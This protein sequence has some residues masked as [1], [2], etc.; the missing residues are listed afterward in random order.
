MAR[1]AAI[2]ITWG[3]SVRGREGK[4][5]EVFMES[6]QFWGKQ[7]ADG[8]IEPPETFIAEDGSGGM[9]ILR[10]KSD[11]LQQLNETDDARKLLSK[12]QLIVEDLRSHWYYTGDEEITRETSLFAQVANELGYM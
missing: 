9:V 1:N 4:S 10:G 2:V 12:A 6:L 11:V 5:L 7:A 8:K 3:P